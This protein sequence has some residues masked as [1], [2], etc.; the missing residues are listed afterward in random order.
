MTQAPLIRAIQERLRKG[1]YDD[2]FTPFSVAGV[3]FEFTAAMRGTK[4]HA[5]D[6]VLL[7]D[8]TAGDYG[9]RDGSRIRQRVEALSRALD[10]TES[11]L[12]ITAILAGA[13]LLQSV[14]AMT[15]TCRVL[16]VEGLAIDAAGKPVD[17][18]TQNRLDDRIRLLLPLDLPPV[19]SLE[20]GSLAVEQLIQSLTTA[21]VQPDLLQAVIQASAD[22]ESAVTNAIAKKIGEILEPEEQ[23]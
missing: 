19:V 15:E 3:A 5:L 16:Y 20:G 7:I 2:I 4:G 10:I 8:T 13:P 12:V 21:I 22:G 11:R 17:A 18:I 6:L 23:S 1:G 14:D 9:D